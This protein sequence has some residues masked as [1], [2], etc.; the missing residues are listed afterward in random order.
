MVTLPQKQLHVLNLQSQVSV[1]DVAD[2]AVNRPLKVLLENYVV[3]QLRDSLLQGGLRHPTKNITKVFNI[4]LSIL[5][6]YCLQVS[7]FPSLST[8][9]HFLPTHTYRTLCWRIRWFS[10]VMFLMSSGCCSCDE[11]TLAQYLV[12]LTRYICF[13]LF[14]L[15]FPAA[16]SVVLSCLMFSL[17]SCLFFLFRR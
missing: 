5:L 10:S 14:V 13:N 12:W 16:S 3:A 2:W 4:F 9:P 15:S 17:I 7:K 11:V 6:S 1:D 8:S